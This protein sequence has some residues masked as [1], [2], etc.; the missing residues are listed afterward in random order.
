M[1]FIG[2][3]WPTN[4]TGIRV[5]FTFQAMEQPCEIHDKKVIPFIYALFLHDG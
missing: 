3:P 4:I 1:A 2:L 5:D